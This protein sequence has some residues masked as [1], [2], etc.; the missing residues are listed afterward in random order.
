MGLQQQ[1]TVRVKVTE[2]VDPVKA[3][4]TLLRVQGGDTEGSHCESRPKG[5]C[6]L[7]KKQTNANQR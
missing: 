7:I 5:G 3:F 4:T 1:F 2:L 6:D